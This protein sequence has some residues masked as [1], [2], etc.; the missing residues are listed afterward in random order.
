VRKFLLSSVVFFALGAQA[1]GLIE[2]RT[3]A[4]PVVG[5]ES[6]ASIAYLGIP[7]AQAPTGQ[8][9]WKPPVPAA[10][11][12][13]PLIAVKYGNQC[14]QLSIMFRRVTGDEDCLNLNVWKPK[15][16][17]DKPLP[18]MVFIHG[19]ANS[20]GASNQKIFGMNLYDGQHLASEGPAIIVSLNY[21][22]GLLGFMAHPELSK[23]SGYGGSGNYGLMDQIQALK[24][25]QENIAAFGGDP[26]N[27]TVFGE[28]AGA[29]NIMALM[30]SSSA[31]GLFHKAIIQSGFLSEIPLKQA[32]Q[33]GT[34]A[35]AAMNCEGPEALDK[36]RA[37][38]LE[39]IVRYGEKPGTM[40]AYSA[41]IDGHLLQSGVL[42]NFQKGNYSQ[43]PTIIG[44]TAD[45]MTS[46]APFLAD[47]ASI[48][49]TNEYE[50]RVLSFF[51][52][53]NGNAVLGRYPV[54][55]SGKTARGVFEGMLTDAFVLCP[56]R[57]IAR[58]FNSNG[59]P[60]YKYLFSHSNDFMMGLGGAFHGIELSYVFNTHFGSP[61]EYDLS[62]QVMRYWTSFAATGKPEA[63]GKTAWPRYS[64]EEFLNLNTPSNSDKGY[65]EEFCDFWD[66]VG[67]LMPSVSPAND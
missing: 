29:I 34:E 65:R 23:E 58:A 50:K 41:T 22:L 10:P 67:E 64:C 18:V 52:S 4:G 66:S 17:S 2:V 57:R 12:T 14:P 48:V 19:G 8:L 30:A 26:D 38:P 11:W 60:V 56:A 9:R 61:R 46:L 7:Y 40:S 1:R 21:R 51:G 3:S 39:D 54:D 55:G 27:V 13:E 37:L 49:T 5:H 20:L 24:W 32:E 25:V 35:A 47:S 6:G 62:K 53:K 33:Q 31:K 43:V 28:S 44:T 59:A 16:K 42:A 63:P 36:L 45:E 15:A